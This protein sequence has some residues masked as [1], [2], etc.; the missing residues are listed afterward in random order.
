MTVHRMPVSYMKMKLD[1]GIP[2]KDML[3]YAS[4]KSV[5]SLAKLG[6]WWTV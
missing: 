4:A 2:V 5:E 1:F 3:K 6:G